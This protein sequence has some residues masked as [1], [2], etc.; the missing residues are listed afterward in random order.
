[1]GLAL[2]VGAA[3]ASAQEPATEEINV[4]EVEEVNAEVSESTDQVAPAQLYALAQNIDDSELLRLYNRR[5]LS[6]SE[7]LI[8]KAKKVRKIGWIV[9]GIC[10]AGG[11][12]GGIMIYQH[13]NDWD[14]GY[15]KNGTWL[16][17]G[18]GIVAGAAVAIGCNL[19]ANSLQKRAWEMQTFTAPIIESEV[20][21]IGANKLTAGVSVMG[22]QYTHTR[23]LGMSFKLNF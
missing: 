19:Y 20:M 1:M 4:S 14:W 13:T 11:I 3:F 21:N 17:I 15:D 7:Q 23:G 5:F 8:A 6:S 16:C 10:T 12:I 2:S 9:G 18:G 22:N